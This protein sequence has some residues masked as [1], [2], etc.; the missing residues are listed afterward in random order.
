MPGAERCSNICPGRWGEC[1]G[2]W[3]AD[4]PV[5]GV[6]LPVRRASAS[7]HWLSR[8]GNCFCLAARPADIQAVPPGSPGRLRCAQRRGWGAMPRARRAAWVRSA[9]WSLSRMRETW[10]CTVLRE[11]PRD[12]AICWL[13][14]PSASR[15]R[16][17]RSR[18]VRSSGRDGLAGLDDRPGVWAR[19]RLATP[20][21][22]TAPPAA[23]VRSAAARPPPS[24][25]RPM[26]PPRRGR[27]R[28]RY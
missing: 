1:A 10:F 19:S 25:G 11:M 27:R 22:K 2:G 21:P 17:S 7:G 9:A 16:T 3:H 14:A 24:A 12:R 26:L 5:R 23:T 28:S 4:C 13:L 18:V 20:A 8:Q 15:S 6:L